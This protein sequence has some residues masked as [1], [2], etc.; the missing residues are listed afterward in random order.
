MEHSPSLDWR[1]KWAPSLKGALT[2]ASRT[3][4]LRVLCHRVASRPRQGPAPQLALIMSRGTNVGCRR[5]D[6]VRGD[7][8]TISGRQRQSRTLQR[9]ANHSFVVVVIDSMIMKS[10][11]VLSL[12]RWRRKKNL[13]PRRPSTKSKSATNKRNLSIEHKQQHTHRCAQHQNNYLLHFAKKAPTILPP[14]CDR[15]ILNHVYRPCKGSF[16]ILMY[17]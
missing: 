13:I 9:H 17:V 3:L 11:C 8:G 10:G 16:P 15:N 4:L 12:Q 2:T 7:G 1:Q 5:F 6:S 14:L